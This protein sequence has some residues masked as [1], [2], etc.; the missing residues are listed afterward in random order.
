M[1]T[2]LYQ[3]NCRTIETPLFD[4]FFKTYLPNLYRE[5]QEKRRMADPERFGTGI[6]DE[7]FA[8]HKLI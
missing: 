3:D 5:I 1:K 6:V 7:I 4:K 2:D 8:R